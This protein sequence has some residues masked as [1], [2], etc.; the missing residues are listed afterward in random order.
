VNEA[1]KQV[2]ETQRLKQWSHVSRTAD[3]G[4]REIVRC[5]IHS[6]VARYR[7]ID[8]PRVPVRSLVVP[9]PARPLLGAVVRDAL[10][11]VSGKQKNSQ[12]FNQARVPF[13]WCV[14]VC[15][16]VCV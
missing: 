2:E 5:V 12:L 3:C 15:V 6:G 7:V 4:P 11:N 9:E 16:S 14:C 1:V 8:D 13:R 10:V